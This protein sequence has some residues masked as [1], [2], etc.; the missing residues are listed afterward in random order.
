MI[1]VVC[2]ICD[3]AN[4]RLMT[5][6]WYAVRQITRYIFQWDS[7]DYKCTTNEGDDY[8]DTD[9]HSE[10]NEGSSSILFTGMM[11]DFASRG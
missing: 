8:S 6:D 11:I 2:L 9:Q 3:S 4:A 7:E 1:A 10:D 5:I